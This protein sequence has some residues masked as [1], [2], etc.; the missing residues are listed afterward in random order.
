VLA[1]AL[2]LGAWWRLR[3][4]G[5]ALLFGDELHT[6]H[7][8]QGGYLH[9]LS[10]FSE[11]G[12]G[13]ALPLLQRVMIDLFGDGHW[14]IRAPAWIPSIALLALVYPVLKPR[15]GAP[16]A[17]AATA[18]VAVSPIL[19][20]YAHFG[21][22]Y[23]AVALLAFGLWA[24]CERLLDTPADRRA[25]AAMLVA[26]CALLPYVHP[27]ALGFVL[28]VIAA[29][30]AALWWPARG[31][32]TAARRRQAIGVAIALAAGGTICL[33]LHL[34]AWS[35]L[36]HFVLA[37]TETQAYYGE[38]GFWD[39]AALLTG[40]RGAS[41]LLCVA[42]LA[43]GVD[44]LRR[45]GTRALPLLAACTG[46]ALAIALV[47]PYGDAYA[48]ARYVLPC[49]V[50]LCVLLAEGL[51]AAA[52]ALAP[53]GEWASRLTV[54]AGLALSAGLLATGPLTI[55]RDAGASH[56]NTYLSLYPLPAFDRAWP[57]APSFYASLAAESRSREAELTLIE[58]PALTT[59]TRHL[60][61][62]YQLMHG[63][64]TL[65]APLPREFPRIP[66]GP[67]LSLEDPERV[68]QSGADYLVLH[69]DVV[70]EIAR[71]W[72]FVYGAAPGASD[73]GSAYMQR[74]ERYGGLLARPHPALVA[75]LT[76]ALGAPVHRDEQ[77]VV[78]RIAKTSPPRS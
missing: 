17:A 55:A 62:H 1:A 43:A 25:P 66:S 10:H 56:A 46:P 74:H 4:V 44:L 52:R 41:Q 38:F 59:R 37:K 45:R 23:S 34:P 9:L 58:S 63:A 7:E 72:R 40:H 20:F 77:I 48:Y 30:C 39:V 75:H 6:L 14:A 11:T 36:Q 61:R 53:T 12:A 57:D 29:T 76:E 16:V 2:L 3:Y 13:M 22:A 64:R 67:Y 50:P 24:T 31:D 51:A 19:I 15:S 5:P 21:R 26:L 27:T 33:V 68:R 47:R 42:A 65:L 60:Y 32:A 70:D 69:L 49:V 8:I 18:L 78:W 71:Y 73:S 35:S 54:L 28:P